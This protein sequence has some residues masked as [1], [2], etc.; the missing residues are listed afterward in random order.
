LLRVSADPLDVV[1]ATEPSGGLVGNYADDDD[2]DDSG[3]V[4]EVLEVPYGVSCN[5]NL[6]G[7]LHACYSS[8]IPQIT[9]VVARHTLT[10]DGPM[11]TNNYPSISG[12]QAEEQMIDSGEGPTGNTN[13]EN[14]KDVGNIFK[15]S[16][17]IVDSRLLPG[18]SFLVSLE[19][20]PMEREGYQ[21]LDVTLTCRDV[22]GNEWD[23]LMEEDDG[24]IFIC[25]GQP[26]SKEEE[27]IY[28]D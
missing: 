13:P 17:K 21:R 22:C 27:S 3:G 26:Q 8:C 5:L 25:V 16:V 14:D 19:C 11:D 7:K 12:E 15:E 20:I 9:H 10:Y 18:G 6:S 24:V 2:N 23:L 1:A 28:L 4:A